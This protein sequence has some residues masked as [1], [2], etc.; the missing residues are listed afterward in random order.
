[1]LR[2]LGVVEYDTV[3]GSGNIHV[4]SPLEHLEKIGQAL[5]IESSVVRTDEELG[6][7][8]V[9]VANYELLRILA[10]IDV[11]RVVN[12]NLAIA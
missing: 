2:Q 1:M 9:F 7:L 12:F 4:I 11:I 3:A 10:E 6:A 8:A 5:E